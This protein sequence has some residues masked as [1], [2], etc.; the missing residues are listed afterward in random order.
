MSLSTHVRQHFL[1]NSDL[2]EEV[3]FHLTSGL[4]D[5]AVFQRAAKPESGVIDQY[6]NA[7]T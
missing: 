2:A 4:I 7:T 1:D 6:I 3:R 5:T